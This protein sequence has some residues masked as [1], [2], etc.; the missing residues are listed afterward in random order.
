[1]TKNYLFRHSTIAVFFAFVLLTVWGCRRDYDDLEEASFPTTGEVFIDGFSAGLQYAAFG[2]SKVTAFEVDNQIAYKG[3]ASMRFEVPDAGDPQGAF[4]GGTYFT[5]VGRD[6]TGYD[7]LTFWIRASKS[8]TIDLLGFGN[9]LGESR[10]VTDLV[11]LKVNSNWQKVIIPIPDAA[12]LTEERGMFY[13]S[14]GPENG[15]GYTF[16]IDEV[17]YEKLGTLAHGQAGILEG[18]DQTVTVETGNKLTMGGFHAIFNMPTGVDQRV[19]VSPHYFTFSSSQTNVATVSSTGEVN[20]LDEGTTVITAK[21]GDIEA[22]GSMTIESTGD[23]VMPLVIAP[24][25]TANADSVISMFSNAYTNVPIDT[26]NTRWEFSTAEDSDIK[27]D[28]DDV[29]R[30]QQLNFVGIEF[31]S[32]TIDA[33][34]MTHFHM[35]LWTPDPTAAPA[36]FKVLLVDFGADGNFDGGDDSSH[37]MAFTAPLLQSENWISIDVPL[38]S[39]AG[40]TNRANLA[41]LVLSGD[42]PNVYIDNVYFYQS[43]VT[44][45]TAPTEA[46]PVPPSRDAADVISVFSDSYT[47]IADTDLNPDWGQATVVSQEEIAGNNTLVY[48]GF[49]YQGIQF[50]SAQDLSGM[51]HLHI[52][53]FSLNSTTL[54]TFLISS[55]PVETAFAMNVP[56][57]GWGA[58]DVP[59][60]SFD[61]VDLA[62]VI[63]M[64]FDGNGEIYMDNIY[65]YKGG[66]TGGEEKPTVAAPTPTR[67]AADVISIFS[68][69]YMNLDATNFNPNWGQA[70]VVTE[71]PIDGNNTLVY[72]GLNYQGIE[73]AAATDV[74]SMTHLHINYWASSSTA[75][76]T[77]LIS[78]G[79][80]ET[81]VDLTVPTSEW[82]TIEIPLTSFDPVNLADLI[83][84]KFEGDGNVY[85][86]NIYFYKEGTTG[87]GE[88]PT[89]AAPAPTRDAAD[90]I[91]VFSDAY[92][93][94]D[95][96]NFNPNWGQ[97]TVVTE[98]AIDG[99]NT[100]VYT[101]LNYQGIEL[102]ASTDVSSMTHLHINYWTANSTALK[103]FLISTGPVETP[104]DLTVPTNGWGTIEIPL[105]SFDPVNV[106]DLIQFKFEG[107]GNVYLDNIYFYKE[108][109]TGGGTPTEAAPMPM[110]DEADVISVFSDTYMNIMGTD[111]NPNWG[112][113]TVVSE[114]SIDGNNT[115]LYTGLNYQGVIL[116]SAT[117]VTGMS[118]L[119]INFWTDNSTALKAFLISTGPVETPVDLTVPTSGWGTIEIPLSSFD[120]VNLGDIIQMKFEGDGNVYLDN[121]YFYKEPTTGGGVPT[122][123]APTPMRDAG[124][125]ISIFSDAYT[126]V[127]DSDLNPNWGQATVVTEESIAGNNT[128]LYTG[129][130]YQG[131]Q[132]GS[133]QDASGMTH[134]HLDVWTDNSSALSVFLISPGPVETPYAL[135]VPTSG[136]L[137]IDIPLSEFSPVDLADLFQFKFE[138][139]GNVYLDNIYF[140]K[141]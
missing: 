56:T 27:V 22:V 68:D 82:G 66:N 46:A 111:L 92:M 12:K 39:F 121:I 37:E 32:Q 108:P 65:F 79:P 15:E 134:L 36:A 19:E 75:L 87:G 34:E 88:K 128:L 59:L 2:G 52:D 49:N 61:P 6:L 9:D 76:K 50:G 71:E 72:T 114:V 26:W 107:D 29:K 136:W 77:F 28:G 97:A 78:T 137:T 25:P 115:L 122:E 58:I 5:E 116:G 84:F 140:Y 131:L 42:L 10:F 123:A 64:K 17:Q 109:T 135:T 130:N 101:G 11:N 129:L 73:L 7:A 43:G 16:W 51:T 120:P 67:D 41:Q 31:T 80:V 105:S 106:A 133:N 83:Q 93:N 3:E 44:E 1:M 126:N 138:G 69:S 70:T 63:Q 33:S 141:E 4:A 24:V 90:V 95:A 113:A 14:E 139:D 96:T 98:E 55:G 38:S 47:N 124:S 8:A 91:S 127:A 18:Q 125:V 21:L 110:R 85:L 13:Y 57:T 119:H 89:E 60:S 103:T 20:V 54:N 74:S 40:L 132:L 112:Q 104:V 100:L 86:D 35:D 45:M 30:Y 53:Y 23:P 48:R 102:A 118:H 81:P 94:L 117:D 62:D 99:N